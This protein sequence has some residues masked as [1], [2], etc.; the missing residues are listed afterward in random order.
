MIDQY[1]VELDS[2]STEVKLCAVGGLGCQIVGQMIEQEQMDVFSIVQYIIRLDG[3]KL[4]LELYAIAKKN[5]HST[6][7]SY[8]E[9]AW[10][11]TVGRE[12]TETGG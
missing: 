12:T 5:Q 9:S 10:T 8:R 7:F 4:T 2:Y 6:D 11:M 3:D 1:W